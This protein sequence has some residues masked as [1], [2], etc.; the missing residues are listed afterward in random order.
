MRRG[1]RTPL[2]P[3]PHPLSPPAPFLPQFYS[4]LEGKLP[5]YNTRITLPLASLKDKFFGQYG[6][7]KE[8][9]LGAQADPGKAV[10][11]LAGGQ[12][13]GRGRVGKGW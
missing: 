7:G 2:P 10:R 12:V 4:T 9:G 3:L 1:Y 8:A 11:G 5:L 13:G 6:Q